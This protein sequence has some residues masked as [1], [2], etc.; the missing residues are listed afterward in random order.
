MAIAN[1]P[2]IKSGSASIAALTPIAFQS[3]NGWQADAIVVSATGQPLL[4][5][6][7]GTNVQGLLLP[8]GVP[9]VISGT[10]IGDFSFEPV[11][12]AGSIFW[13]ASKGVDVSVLIA[14]AGG[15]GGGSGLDDTNPVL[16]NGAATGTAPNAIDVTA[17]DNTLQ[18]TLNDIGGGNQ[19]LVPLVV[20][21]NFTT[22]V[23]KTGSGTAIWF[24]SKGTGGTSFLGA[25][26]GFVEDFATSLTS[27]RFSG[28]FGDGVI[29]KLSKAGLEL[30]KATTQNVFASAGNL[31]V[32]STL[33]SGKLFLLAN[34][35]T[36]ATVSNGDVEFAD[37]LTLTGD[38]LTMRPLLAG[39]VVQVVSRD[40]F[41]YLKVA[42]AGLTL[43]GGTYDWVLDNTG[44]ITGPNTA[45]T[46]Q[47]KIHKVLAGTAAD[48]VA[49]VS[50][51]PVQQIVFGASDSGT[52]GQTRELNYGGGTSPSTSGGTVA[53]QWVAPAAFTMTALRVYC[54]GAVGDDQTFTVYKNNSPTALTL[55][56][57]SGGQTGTATGS[58]AVALND[59]LTLVTEAGAGGAGGTDVMAFVR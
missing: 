14:S 44:E 13:I 1:I 32:G 5:N 27:L 7:N 52:A 55:T 28:G 8:V 54:G 53:A 58:V 9:I 37:N 31:G 57:L 30:V 51:I 6:I 17:L 10:I 20:E 25:I 15:G 19:V 29:A 3:Q 45:G 22:D 16:L 38:G 42:N 49:V 36:Q 47:A 41:T 59:V 33:A 35:D 24:Q 48:D 56:I 12:S 40:G 46:P 4:M 34:N 23:V 21:G 39:G 11:S 43:G 18:F 2:Y 50:Q 26:T